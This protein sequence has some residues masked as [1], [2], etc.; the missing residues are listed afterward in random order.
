[1]KGPARQHSHGK[2]VKERVAGQVMEEDAA[3]MYGYTGTL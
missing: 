3:S 2:I 1:M